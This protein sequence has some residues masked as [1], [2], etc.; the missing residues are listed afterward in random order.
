M[1]YHTFYL[2]DNKKCSQYA[3]PKKGY[4]KICPD[5]GTET[6]IYHT[7]GSKKF[8]LPFIIVSILLAICIFGYIC[9]LFLWISHIPF[10]NS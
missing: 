2:C 7:T 9:L 3:K 5:C 4:E 10:V 8:K 6:L 1:A